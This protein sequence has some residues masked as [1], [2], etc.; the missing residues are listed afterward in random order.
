MSVPDLEKGGTAK[1]ERPP[2][3]RLRFDVDSRPPPKDRTVRKAPSTQSFVRNITNRNKHTPIDFRDGARVWQ[4]YLEE[5]EDIA[6]YKAASWNTTLDTL[7]IFAGLFAGVVSSFIIDARRDIQPSSDER[8]LSGIFDWLR[9][10]SI[11]GDTFNIPDAAYWVS[12]M[13]MVSLFTTLFSAIVGVLA[14][15]WLA[16]Y[17]PAS[18]RREARDAYRRYQLDGQA[19]RWHLNE[20]LIF[21]PMTVQGAAT[22]FL[23]GLILQLQDD[24]PTISRVLLTFSIGGGILYLILTVFPLVDSSSPF[25]TPISELWDAFYNAGNEKSSPFKTD[26]NDGLADILYTRLIQSPKPH[27]VDE[28]V[29]EIGLVAFPQR[30]VRYLSSDETHTPKIL[31]ERFRQCVTSMPRDTL[32]EETLHN[33]LLAL[34]SFVVCYDTM[35]GDAGSHPGTLEGYSGLVEVLREALEPGNPLHRWNELPEALRPLLFALRAN[36][37]LLLSHD[38]LKSSHTPTD[39]DSSEVLD[40]PWEMLYQ[41]I[42][43]TDRIRFTIAACRGLV[44]GGA[45]LKTISSFTL[46]LC[47]AKAALVASETGRTT[48]W[49]S[50]VSGK[51]RGTVYRLAVR[52][53]STLHK[54]TVDGLAGW[55]LS[56]CTSES[57]SPTSLPEFIAYMGDGNDVSRSWQLIETVAALPGVTAVPVARQNHALR[58]YATRMVQYAFPARTRVATS[59]RQ[60]IT[61][62]AESLA[63]EVAYGDEDIQQGGLELLTELSKADVEMAKAIGRILVGRIRMAFREYE[64]QPH[65]ITVRFIEKIASQGPAG[66]FV[67]VLTDVIP[68]LIEV[69]LEEETGS[70]RIRPLAV[71]VL[72]SLWDKG[73]VDV[74]TAILGH[75]GKL[76]DSDELSY[77][78]I[79]DLRLL[80]EANTPMPGQR[81]QSL[82]FPWRTFSEFLQEVLDRMLAKLFE[83]AIYHGS[84][85]HSSSAQKLIASVAQDARYQV[86]EFDA[87]GWFE[88]ATAP[89]INRQSRVNALRILEKSIKRGIRVAGV[90]KD[91]IVTNS[92]ENVVFYGL[93]PAYSVRWISCLVAVAK[94]ISFPEIIPFLVQCGRVAKDGGDA[95]TIIMDFLRSDQ[96]AHDS[97]LYEGLTKLIPWDTSLIQFDIIHGGGATTCRWVRVLADL[98]PIG[99]LPVSQHVEISR[100][101]QTIAAFRK[102]A[103]EY[104][105]RVKDAVETALNSPPVDNK[106]RDDGEKEQEGELEGYAAIH[107]A[108]DDEAAVVE[109]SYLAQ[110]SVPGP[111]QRLL[112]NSDTSVQVNL[113]DILATLASLYPEDFP[114][115]PN[116]ILT[117]A[118]HDPSTYVRGAALEFLSGLAHSSDILERVLISSHHTTESVSD[119]A[120]PGVLRVKVTDLLRRM[121]KSDTDCLVRLEAVHSLA[122]VVAKADKYP[123][124]SRIALEL[125][126]EGIQDDDRELRKAW[127]KIFVPQFKDGHTS[128]L[129]RVF[130]I[131]TQGE[132]EEEVETTSNVLGK[133]LRSENRELR[134]SVASQLGLAMANSLKQTVVPWATTRVLTKLTGIRH[135]VQPMEDP[136]L[137]EAPPGHSSWVE[138][139]ALLGRNGFQGTSKLISFA[140]L[141]DASLTS[142]IHPALWFERV[143]LRDSVQA[144]LP[145]CVESALEMDTSVPPDMRLKTVELMGRLAGVVKDGVIYEGLL[146]DRKDSQIVHRLCDIAIKDS[147]SS[148]RWSAFNLLKLL[149]TETIRF[150]NV[151]KPTL[152]RQLDSCF[153]DADFMKFRSNAIAFIHQLTEQSEAAYSERFNDIISPS[154]PHLLKMALLA[155]DKD[156]EPLRKQAERILLENL[157]SY[158]TATKV[159]LEV[160]S[161]IPAMIPTI[162]VEGRRIV[163]QL[164]EALQISDDTLANIT[165]TVAPL[166]RTTTSSFVRANAMEFLSRLYSANRSSKPR[167]IESAIPEIIAL[168]LDEKDDVGGVRTTATR[169]LVALCS[170]DMSGTGSRT[171]PRT[172]TSVLEQLT[173]LAMRFMDLLQN[174]NLRPSVVELLSLM[175]TE[176]NVRRA[177]SMQIISLAFGTDSGSLQ[178]HTELLARLIAEGRFGGESIDRVV[179]LLASALVTRPNLTRYRAEILAALSCH[180]ESKPNVPIDQGSESQFVEP[181]DLV[182]W[183]VLALFGRHA[184]VRE[185]V[186]WSGR[187]DAIW[188]LKEIRERKKAAEH[189]ANGEASAK[190]FADPGIQDTEHVDRDEDGDSDEDDAT[191]P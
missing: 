66:P 115:V 189:T 98:L 40:R 157:T 121:V 82:T 129:K 68:R 149:L 130:D 184:T 37:I 174:A 36:I 109:Q 152:T 117:M 88:N 52:Y 53:L 65:I 42:R 191:G 49:A 119:K 38:N 111:L 139:I 178:G 162:T 183:F 85:P 31:L 76:L 18:T 128:R 12:A 172:R 62:A 155:T 75:L 89:E 61:E 166:L 9:S 102:I 179:L 176:S 148:L 30:W 60:F 10:R 158:T 81:L 23:I 123:E 165:P 100:S 127:L 13:W 70:D 168:A 110:H 15:A 114:E 124:E 79:N 48:E 164:A 120:S 177:I 171:V 188:S 108:A 93:H 29:A 96:I 140:L 112:S 27:H 125:F 77:T 47:L 105:A 180:Y 63:S 78:L 14:K 95:Q 21:V 138:I 167:L 8:L 25:N 50:T 107:S 170:D 116:A 126:D 3:D 64:D 5:A 131:A 57:D 135:P 146:V 92:P 80:L 190:I 84:Y 41:E 2:S 86:Q 46:S 58:I 67:S 59:S 99:M 54:A 32:R 104:L 35:V 74:K 143:K 11:N 19:Q 132:D 169:L 175:A 44:E 181:K 43:S 24:S 150:S 34:H 106:T 173:P 151:V 56:L 113:A 51:H 26:I 28:A 73:F 160:L 94:H 7:L 186:E 163:F 4:L 55:D 6:R 45:N 159:N 16:K 39:F 71:K 91:S 33:Y 118:M 22:I 101:L 122:A 133:L 161:A 142:F 156:P 69:S 97:T 187:C 1:A 182:D 72:R 17:V 145:D 90:I 144:E 87:P 141:E 137:N 185:V 154:V 20:V 134:E 153:K 83:I 147:N 136:T 103:W